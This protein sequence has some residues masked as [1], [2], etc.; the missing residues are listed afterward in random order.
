MPRPKLPPRINGPYYDKKDRKYKIRIFDGHGHQ[1]DE[2]FDTMTEAEAAK[3]LAS[4]E[5]AAEVPRSI[6]DLLEEYLKEKQQRSKAKAETCAMQQVHLRLFFQSHLAADISRLTPRRAATL[7]QSFVETPVERTGKL[8][9]AATHR[10]YLRLAHTFFDWIVR[11]G[12]VRTNPFDGIEPVGRVSTGKPQLRL[13]EAQRYRDTA[14]RIF[15]ECGDVIALAAVVPLYLGL[16]VSE[17]LRRK[18]RDVDQNGTLLWID[19]GKTKNARRHLKIEAP[20]L[21]ERLARLASTRHSEEPLFGLS[22]SGQPHKRQVLHAAVQRICKAAGVPVVCPHS[23]R[24]LWATLSIE[25]GAASHA[26]A[27][28]L[29]HGSFAM[30]AKHYAQPEALAGARSARVIEMLDCQPE[31]AAV[32]RLPPEKLVALIPAATLAQVIELATRKPKRA[33][34]A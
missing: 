6:A 23:F 29:G 11:K 32:A 1:T 5:L 8:R 7:Y 27:A 12:Y 4:A 10:H 13:E 15:D 28:A 30:T 22:K 3:T 21:A 19:K 24:G 14:F 18:A 31:A 26:V 33:P 25:S 17:I 34:T 16:R 2:A 9:E 20:A